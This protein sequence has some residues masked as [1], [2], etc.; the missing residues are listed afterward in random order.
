[1]TSFS[2]DDEVRITCVQGAFQGCVFPSTLHEFATRANGLV[3]FLHICAAMTIV[4]SAGRPREPA[5]ALPA[6]LLP[7]ARFA[8]LRKCRS[9]SQR[10][11]D[12]SRAT[13][14]RNL[15]PSTAAPVLLS[16]QQTTTAFAQQLSRPWD[17]KAPKG[18]QGFQVV[19]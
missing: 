8:D 14:K 17:T 11:N 12:L 1:M 15:Y 9:D 16:T 4:G 7:R 2:F 19:S 6:C 13:R 5:N 3:A 18:S 10:S